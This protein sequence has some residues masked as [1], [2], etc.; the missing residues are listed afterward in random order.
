MT[1]AGTTALHLSVDKGSSDII[2]L[3]VGHGIDLSIIDAKGLTALHLALGKEIIVG[4]TDNSPQL[5]E[6]KQDMCVQ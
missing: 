3:L 5:S 1:G 2:E 4:I 6:V